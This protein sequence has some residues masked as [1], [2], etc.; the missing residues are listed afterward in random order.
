MMAARPKTLPAA[1]GP[2]LVGAAL[3]YAD[4][5]FK[6][7]PALACLLCALLLQMGSNLA[8]DYFDFFTGADATGRLGP[9][10]VT[11]SGLLSPASVRLGMIVVFAAAAL[12]GLYLV[13]VGGWPIL[14]VGVAAILAA[15]AYTGGP[16]PFGYH[17]LGDLFVFL[18]FGLVAVG[19]TYYVQAL[20]LNRLAILAGVAPGVLI[21]AI[22]VVNNLRDLESD[23]RV[24][25]R[26][27]A[28]LLGQHNT[29]RWY[30]LLLLVAYA[31]PLVMVLR[32]GQS[33]W[34]LLPWLTAPLAIRLLRPIWRATD[35]PTLNAT[36]AGTARLSLLFSVAL[37]V[38][39]IIA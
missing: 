5:S 6:L 21:T 27:L 12:V 7:L 38:G 8:N 32:T 33:A 10:R 26:T 34:V 17:G 1:V 24:G 28:V 14:A 30:T 35:G 11:S 2:V 20:H 15:L 39:L 13:S 22:L 9:Q 37:A 3:A 29:R 25:K 31:V 4:G 16:F 18:F 36:L 23:A 19:G